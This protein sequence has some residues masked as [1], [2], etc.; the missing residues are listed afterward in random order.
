MRM[1]YILLFTN[2][3]KLFEFIKCSNKFCAVAYQHLSVSSAEWKLFSTQ[4][5]DGNNH[6]HNGLSNKYHSIFNKIYYRYLWQ[7]LTQ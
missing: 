2:F 7:D 5:S 4:F 6:P 1:E 3:N